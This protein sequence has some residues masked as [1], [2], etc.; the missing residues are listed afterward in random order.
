MAA[1]RKCSRTATP[2]HTAA[3]G[4][5]GSGRFPSDVAARRGRLRA[6][7]RAA[8]PGGAGPG[9]GAAPPLDGRARPERCRRRRS[10]VS[11]RPAPGP[12]PGRDGPGD[13]PAPARART[14]APRPEP[15]V[16]LPGLLCTSLRIS[17]L[18]SP[19]V[20]S[21]IS[22]LFL[23]TLL[24]SSLLLLSDS[25]PPS[26]FPDPISARSPRPCVTRLGLQARPGPGLPLVPSG[27]PRCHRGLPFRPGGPGPGVGIVSRAAASPHPHLWQLE[28]EAGTLQPR[29]QPA[30]GRADRMGTS[31][32]SFQAEPLSWLTHIGVL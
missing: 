8:G 10:P 6:G 31:C 7:G 21:A 25:A 23:S 3:R 17:A 2:P 5:S 4:A 19:P 11:D 27:A 24:L 22:D 16:Q 30:R 18:L 9:R 26:P 1:E 15:G 13:P 14:W 20:P 32:L 12:A 29:S 28:T